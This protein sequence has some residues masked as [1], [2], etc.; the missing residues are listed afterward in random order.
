MKTAFFKIVLIL[1]LALGTSFATDDYDDDWER[2]AVPKKFLN[3]DCKKLAKKIWN[4]YMYIY[5]S[6]TIL[7]VWKDYVLK[8][9]VAPEPELKDIERMKNIRY[10]AYNT[11]KLT[12]DFDFKWINKNT[13]LVQLFSPKSERNPDDSCELW[14][15]EEKDDKVNAYHFISWN[16]PD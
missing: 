11:D 6:A 14:L 7:D 16:L 15:F 13:L 4:E 5:Y 9:F 1:F 12:Y 2:K 10:T 3:K 8:L